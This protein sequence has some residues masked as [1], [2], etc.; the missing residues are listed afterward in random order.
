MYTCAWRVCAG[1]EDR[2]V[3]LTACCLPNTVQMRDWDER[4]QCWKRFQQDLACGR[5][6]KVA[7]RVNGKGKGFF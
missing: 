1:H 2:S 4:E 3:L 6:K 5:A 7:R